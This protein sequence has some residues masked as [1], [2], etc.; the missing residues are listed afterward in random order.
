MDMSNF[1]LCDVYVLIISC[2]S[3]LNTSV[4][5]LIGINVNTHQ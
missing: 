5:I 4:S 3:S 2:N 1:S